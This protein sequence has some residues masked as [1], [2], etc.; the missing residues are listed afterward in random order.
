MKKSAVLSSSCRTESKTRANQRLRREGH[1]PG[2]IYG[3]NIDT[4]PIVVQTAELRKMLSQNGR[5]SVFT[6]E[7][8]GGKS[9]SVMLREIQIQPLSGEYLH[10]NFQQVSL[11]EAI[12]A[13]VEIALH[14]KDAIERQSLILLQQMMTLS[15]KGL[16]SDIPDKIEIDAS[17]LQPGESLTISDLNLPEGITAETSADQVIAIV[18]RAKTHETEEE[19]PEKEEG[20]GEETNTEK[21]E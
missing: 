15:V 9:Y 13:D 1:L 14:G 7:T 12:K 17:H 11:S 19:Q 18:H 16:P 6:I 10:V 5:N 4:V 8:D 3:K 21:S 20:S 2:C